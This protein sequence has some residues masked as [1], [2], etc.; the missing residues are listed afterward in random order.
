MNISD[1][2]IHINESL[3]EEARSALENAMRKIEGVV[4]PRF[5]AG[6]EHLLLIAYDTEKTNT[7]VLLEKARAA[8]YTAQLIGM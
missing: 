3:S 2:M 8:G 7:A 6:K 1:V 5:N 4:T